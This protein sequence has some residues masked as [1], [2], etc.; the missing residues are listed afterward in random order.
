V[1][2]ERL[3]GIKEVTAAHEMLHAAYARMSDDE[4][5]KVDRLTAEAVANL[6]D[7][8]ILEVVDNYRSDDPA[9]V[10]NELHSILGTEVSDLPQ[11][12]EEHYARFFDDRQN[13]VNLAKGYESVFAAIDD[14]L[15]ETK[16]NID[17]LAKEIIVLSS[18]LAILKEDLDSDSARLTSL[19]G[20]GN[21]SEYNAGVPAYN[22]KV[23]RYN[24]LIK[25]YKNTISAHNQLVEDYNKLAV[26]QNQLIQSINS[27]YDLI[28][29]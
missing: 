4:R 3:D 19:R 5:A 8:R 12:L 28:P 27:Q 24:E 18:E 1:T 11:E 10:P 14:K 17:Q 22:S 25:T 16:L 26:T 7:E 21:I 15:E 23:N 6:T 29:N 13:V 20:S 2:D 9:S